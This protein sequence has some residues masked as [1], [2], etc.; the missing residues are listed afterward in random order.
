MEKRN[1]VDEHDGPT[2]TIDTH[3]FARTFVRIF[4][5]LT[6]LSAPF[7]FLLFVL[8][9]FLGFF[10]CSR[11]VFLHSV[12]LCCVVWCYVICVVLCR[13]VCCC[14]M[15]RCVVCC[16]VLLCCVEGGPGPV[17]L[18]H[19]VEHFSPNLSL[20]VEPVPRWGR[21]KEPVRSL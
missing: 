17:H 3:T 7:F 18:P 16:C 6:R 19:L 1:N 10:A 13:V 20:V 15:R 11:V 4:T 8:F 2:S 9:L 12:V 21:Q 5:G 14:V